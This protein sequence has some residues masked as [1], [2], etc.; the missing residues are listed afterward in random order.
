M[1]TQVSWRIFFKG[2]SM[3]KDSP[4]IQGKFKGTNK[5]CQQCIKECKQFENVTVMQCN[6][7][8]NQKRHAT[9]PLAN[10]GKNGY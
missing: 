4:R 2:E 1:V 10:E 7:V 5:L 9:L 3:E 8:S 6:F